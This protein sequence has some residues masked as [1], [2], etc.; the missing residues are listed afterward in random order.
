MHFGPSHIETQDFVLWGI[1]RHLPRRSPILLMLLHEHAYCY[2]K[3]CIL[4]VN[5]SFAFIP[6]NLFPYL[7]HNSIHLRPFTILEV[8]RDPLLIQALWSQ[9]ILPP[10]SDRVITYPPRISLPLYHV[11]SL[12][13]NL[14]LSLS[15]V[16]MWPPIKVIRDQGDSR[17]PGSV[18]K[19]PWAAGEGQGKRRKR[20]K[21]KKKR[22][23]MEAPSTQSPRTGTV[24]LSTKPWLWGWW[25][26]LEDF[27]RILLLVIGF[28]ISHWFKDIS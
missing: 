28:G 11:L 26:N 7:V 20:E 18:A 1:S 9:W 25:A 8:Y 21:K 19:G 13:F 24:I 15:G 5:S 6:W 16:R 10:S 3:R 12:A 27:S 23:K 14:S 2:V 22:R 4:W 17:P